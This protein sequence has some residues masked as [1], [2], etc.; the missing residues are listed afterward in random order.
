M[1]TV[2]PA[3]R[4]YLS[5]WELDERGLVKHR[6]GEW[7]WTDWGQNM[8]VAVLENAWFHLALRGAF[9]MAHLLGKSEDAAGFRKQM[10]RIEATFNPTFWQD[11]FYR[12]PTHEGET[13]DRANALAVVAG[14]ASPDYYP[15][16]TKFL[17]TNMHASP[18]MEKY[19]L[20]A[21]FLMGE[22]EAGIERM[23][24]RYASM[25]DCPETTL[26][27]NFARPGSDE[28]GSGTYNHAWSGGPLTMMHQYIAGIEPTA[29]GFK[30]FSVKP[31]LGPLKLVETT[32]PTPHGKIQ[33]VVT[34]DK[35]DGLVLK[36]VVPERTE[37]D[38]ELGGLKK[39]FKEGAYS[40]KAE[41]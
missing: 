27:E 4:D 40:W 37:A 5:V 6:T 15:A 41:R 17:Q 38:V 7:D 22:P 36:L 34:R 28:P 16:I 32:V 18:Y 24:G 9:E 19:V 23:L 2:Y 8:D 10:E 31:Q 11:E 14:L 26:W 35:M 33:L 39:T 25:I 29:P 13:D 1:R 3:V 21:F 12:S 20:E 30:R